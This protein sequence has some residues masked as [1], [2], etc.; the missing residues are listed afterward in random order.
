MEV[1]RFLKTFIIAII[2]IFSFIGVAKAENLSLQLG[3]STRLLEE[4]GDH[5]G[6]T[7][8]ATTG[9]IDASPFKLN[10]V[11]SGAKNHFGS[12]YEVLYETEPTSDGTVIITCN[13]KTRDDVEKTQEYTLIYNVTD[14]ITGV[15]T[16]SLDN[17]DHTSYNLFNKLGMFSFTSIFAPDRLN[18][19]V[20]ALSPCALDSDSPLISTLPSAA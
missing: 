5:I 20:A 1:N 3:Y 15:V 11:E 6:V 10:Y 17:T 14:E 7:C 8:S 13:Y 18:I 4:N 12:Y 16:F 9:D 19:S 2:C